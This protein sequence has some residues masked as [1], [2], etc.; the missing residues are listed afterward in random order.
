MAVRSWLLNAQANYVGYRMN[1][2]IICGYLGRL[3]LEQ[4]KSG[5]FGM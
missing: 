5:V 2:N 3:C 4:A 1:E